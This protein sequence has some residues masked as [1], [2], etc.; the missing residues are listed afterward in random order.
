LNNVAFR[1]ELLLEHPLPDETGLYRGN[2]ALHAYRLQDKGHVIWRQPL[3]RAWHAPP[4]GV[5][6]FVIR[7]LLIGHDWRLQRLLLA[8]AARGPD[9]KAA[10][11]VILGKP[12]AAAV[13]AERVRRLARDE[14]HGVGRLVASLPIV[15]AA[16]GV[17]SVGY[18]IT[19]VRPELLLGI[20]HRML[21]G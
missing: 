4:R 16:V 10:R 18:L 19:T 21:A 13:F 1:R 8:R 9:C 11:G 15:A 14:D 20:S 2:C 3:A 7:F 5:T 6:Q 12:S 17:I